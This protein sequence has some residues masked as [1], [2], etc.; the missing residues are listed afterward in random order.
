M[1]LR[2]ILQVLAVIAALT[3][4]FLLARRVITGGFDRDIWLAHRTDQVNNPRLG[5]VDELIHHRLKRG[6]PAREVVALLGE[7]D[8]KETNLA[9]DEYDIS[10]EDA[11]KTQ[12]IYVYPIGVRGSIRQSCASL[13]MPATVS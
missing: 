1:N 2:R 11:R 6:M 9:P 7:P 4:F 5:M 10:K 12:V 13:S 3:I 8:H